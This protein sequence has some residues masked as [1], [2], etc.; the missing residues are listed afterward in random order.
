[1]DIALLGLA[2]LARM[3]LPIFNKRELIGYKTMK[4]SLKNKCFAPIFAPSKN[5]NGS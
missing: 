5:K 3:Y 1:V 2:E 4:N